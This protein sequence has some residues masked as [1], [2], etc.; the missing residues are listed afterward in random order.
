MKV[1]DNI[2]E[3]RERFDFSFTVRRV[4]LQLEKKV[5]EDAD[6]R[7]ARRLAEHGDAGAAA[8][9][10]HLGAFWRTWPCWSCSTPC[11]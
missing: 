9:R 6:R 8:L 1:V 2:I 11:R 7:A 5:V 10:R 3:E 4:N